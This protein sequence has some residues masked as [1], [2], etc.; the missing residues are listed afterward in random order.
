[1][2]ACSYRVLSTWTLAILLAVAVVAEAQVNPR[3]VPV[4]RQPQ[5]RFN[6]GQD[7]QPIFEGWTPNDD[8]SYQFHFGYLNRNYREQPSVPIGESNFFSPGLEDR[9]Q[10]TYFFPRTQRYQFEVRVPASFGPSDELTWT[11]THNGSTQL[12]IGWLQAEWEID[13]NTIT[14]NTRMGNG[15]DVG[16]LYANTRPSISVDA[17]ASTVSVGQSLTLTA[18][19]TDDELP[20]ELPPRDP[21]AR[22]RLPTLTPPEDAPDIP[23]NVEWYSRPSAPRNGLAVRWLVYRGPADAVFEPAGFQLSV[24]EKEVE[25][26]SNPIPTEATPPPEATHLEGDGW[27]SATFET[28]VAFDEPG[29]YTLRAFA[30]DAML[31]TSADVTVTVQ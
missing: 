16:Q 28:S 1:M 30:S 8:G 17:S 31:L 5:Q 21:S 19:L 26:A 27:T 25:Q 24:S 11:V 22:R 6:A 20:T 14:S 3:D 23:D 2:Q 12:A 13:V 7:I 10:P 15:R 9:G 29:T 4:V 18:R